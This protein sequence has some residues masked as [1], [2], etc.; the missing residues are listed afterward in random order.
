[1]QV[2]R[3]LESEKGDEQPIDTD[4]VDVPTVGDSIAAQMSHALAFQRRLR[5][6]RRY[7]LL[8]SQQ[9]FGVHLL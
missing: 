2:V 6:K 4:P 3:C 1:L 5:Q 9:R 7:A 8:S